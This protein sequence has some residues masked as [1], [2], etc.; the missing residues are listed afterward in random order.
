MNCSI[1]GQPAQEPVV[2]KNGDIFEKR[3]IVKHIE[4]NGTCPITNEAMGLEDLIP[5]RLANSNAVKPRQ[6]S[7]TSVP[8]LLQTFQNEWDSLML[9]T[10]HLKKQLE[11]TRQELSQALYQSDAAC[12]VIARLIKERDGART[13][14]EQ[15]RQSV[16]RGGKMEVDNG[17]PGLDTEARNK[18]QAKAAELSA[19]RKGFEAGPKVASIQDIKAFKS[20]FSQTPHKA[21]SPG[22]LSVDIH[23][24]DENIIVTGGVDST[25]VIT[26]RATGKKEATLSGHTKKVNVSLFHPT[27]DIVLTGSSD[28]TVKIW[29]RGGDNH[30]Q[31]AYTIAAHASDVHAI[32]LHATNDYIVSGSNDSWAFHNIETGKNFVTGI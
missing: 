20:T 5:L 26:N 18:I 29:S 1:S 11:T 30:F 4:A 2:S 7:A 17:L 16:G 10:F 12:R 6:L 14:L 3:L 22:V 28:H 19:S 32:S 31:A 13:E 27:K 23:P 21:S 15:L 25:A 9:E 24:I 8:G